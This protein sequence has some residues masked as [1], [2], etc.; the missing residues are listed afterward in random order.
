MIGSR[1]KSIESCIR[2]ACSN[3]FR[4][5]TSGNA[6]RAYSVEGL[7]DVQLEETG[8]EDLC[9]RE[10]GLPEASSSV[11]ALLKVESQIRQASTVA[12]VAG[13][14]AFQKT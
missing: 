5:R 6:E 9:F 12:A 8:S 13:R 1:D 3:D 7:H 10:L 2:L 14:T 11:C 4:E